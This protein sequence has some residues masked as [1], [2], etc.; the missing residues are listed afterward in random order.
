L[1]YNDVVRT[2]VGKYDEK[3]SSI[4]PDDLLAHVITAL[5]NRN[6]VDVNWHPNIYY[7]I[8]ADSF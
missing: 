4:R 2:P 8:P 3:L 5:L 1:L 6:P 7:S